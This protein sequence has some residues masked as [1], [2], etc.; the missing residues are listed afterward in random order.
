MLIIIDKYFFIY[1]SDGKTIYTYI[2]EKTVS[3]FIFDYTKI[4]YYNNDIK[5]FFTYNQEMLKST[6][7]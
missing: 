7:N 2:I 1:H 6:F 4:Q 3:K 5:F